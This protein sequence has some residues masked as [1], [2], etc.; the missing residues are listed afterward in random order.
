MAVC[1]DANPGAGRRASPSSPDGARER[2]EQ[3]RGVEGAAGRRPERVSATELGSP[4]MPRRDHTLRLVAPRGLLRVPFTGLVLPPATE[5]FV[6]IGGGERCPGVCDPLARSS[7]AMRLTE[8]TACSLGL[9]Y[10][11]QSI[12][13]GP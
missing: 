9:E 5:G 3:R 12:S 8:I 7:L 13:Q 1:D 11:S 2:S 10:S 6:D 4:H